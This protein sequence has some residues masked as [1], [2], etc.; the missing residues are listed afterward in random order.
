MRGDMSADGISSGRTTVLT[1]ARLAA[2][3]EKSFYGSV[4]IAGR[5]VI[6]IVPAAQPM[7]LGVWP[8][9]EIDLSGHL[10]L[11]G[12]INAHDHL[13]FSLYPRL[14]DPPYRNYVEWGEDIHKKFADAIARQHAVP[15]NVR[16]WWGGIRNLL[17]GVTTVCHHNPFWSD[18]QN[19]GFPV[20]VLSQYGWAHSLAL[21]GDL[22]QAHAATPHGQPFVLHACEGV[23]DLAAAELWTLDE[24]GLLE[25]NTVLVHG[26]AIGRDGA[27]LVKDRGAS[28]IVCPSS[29][30]FL[31]GRFPNLETWQSVEKLALGSDSPLTAKGDLLDE[32]RFAIHSCRASSARA[33][34]MVTSLPASILHLDDGEGSLNEFGVADLIAVR[35]TGQTPAAQ[36]QV[37]TAED[38]ELVMNAGRVQLVSEA[39]RNRLPPHTTRGL[40]PLKV[41]GVTRWL[42]APVR[43]LLNAAEE[44]LGKNGVHL[45]G[46]KVSMP[47]HV[48]T[49]HAS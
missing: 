32:I 42:R 2:E 38:I 37:L 45:S 4:E 14:A 3:A 47:A 5:R 16:L 21:G 40:E 30:H 28:L 6:Q 24:L 26:L 18:L 22:R 48:E 17:C 27:S 15:K 7:H 43:R 36:L 12:L 46:K 23:D 29:N 19:P 39:L 33:Y 13:E 11:P 1:G 34:R 25:V 9:S 35:D 41:E 10:I 44:A 20:R 8:A 49:C 31:Y